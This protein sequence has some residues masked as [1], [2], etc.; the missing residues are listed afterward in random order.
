MSLASGFVPDPHQKSIT[1]GG[2][3]DASYL[4]TG[5]NGNN[6]RGYAT[7]APDYQVTYTSGGA[8][9][10][11]FYY[12]ANDDGDTT[13]IINA[14]DAKWYCAD[15]SYGTSD[16]SIDFETPASGNYDIWV[17]TYTAGASISGALN[18]TELSG[19][20]PE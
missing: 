17:G 5:E 15:D 6:C 4:G 2:S 20:H 8:S 1:P 10:L 7:S 13:L 16:P 3:V 9:L 19:N 18:V 11:R 14:P 12:L